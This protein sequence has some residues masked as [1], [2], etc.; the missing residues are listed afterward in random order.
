MPAG[1]EHKIRFLHLHG[2]SSLDDL[3]HAKKKVRTVMKYD[4]SSR[5]AHLIGS[6]SR[7]IKI[8]AVNAGFMVTG[9]KMVPNSITP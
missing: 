4:F 7:I 9:H 1:L 3:D 5:A 6:M 2:R 8:E